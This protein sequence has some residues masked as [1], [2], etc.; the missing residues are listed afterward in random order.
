MAATTA[1]ARVSAYASKQ[2]GLFTRE[3]AHLCGLSNEQLRRL[4]EQGVIE[5]LSRNVFRF[6]GSSSTWYQHVLAACLDGG[7]DCVASHRTAAA[8]H[9]LDGF[10]PGGIIEVL[11]PMRVRHRRKDVIV[12]HTRSLPKQDRA[13]V[14]AIPVTSVARTL[15]TLGAVV[16]ATQVEEAYDA[17]ERDGKV[18]RREVEKRYGELRANGRNGIGAMT[19][20]RNG[21]L[22][23]AR[24]PRSVLERR[25]LRLLERA[26]LPT[27][28][29]RFWVRVPDGRAFELDFAIVECQVGLE[30]EGHGTHATRRDR[31]ADHVRRH[32]LEDIG[33]TIRV[34]TYEQVIHE[35]TKV[36]ASV[37]AALSNSPER[38]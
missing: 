21:R 35:P 22:A 37:R 33:W 19:L 10:S 38:L 4:L 34:F 1:L 25:M 26:K 8:L 14:D 32:V 12:H 13:V 7:P 5:R 3:Q 29:T 6:T 16:P 31:A 20:I 11:V 28:V 36:A 23:A 18:R 17:A 27:P 2:F 9:R 24:V 30:V 15:M